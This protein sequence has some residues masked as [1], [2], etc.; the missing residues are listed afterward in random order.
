MPWLLD[1]HGEVKPEFADDYELV[2]SAAATDERQSA[3]DKAR[4][5]ANLV[6]TP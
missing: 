6:P 2:G 1:E 3:I 5:Y 4:A